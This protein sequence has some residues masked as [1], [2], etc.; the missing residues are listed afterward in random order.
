MNNRANFKPKNDNFFFRYINKVCFARYTLQI[1]FKMEFVLAFTGS[2]SS[3]IKTYWLIFL[4][5]LYIWFIRILPS[6]LMLPLIV[7][8]K[9]NYV[10]PEQR[11]EL[12]GV[13]KIREKRTGSLH[14]LK[15]NEKHFYLTH[16][17]FRKF[18]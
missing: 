1:Q 7:K 9:Q 15:K 16:Q 14:C 6:I 17:N 10:D 8:Y 4:S 12:R 11:W 5:S 3:L 18:Q 13:Q 2:Q